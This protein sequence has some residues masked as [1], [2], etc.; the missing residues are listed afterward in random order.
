MRH[1]VPSVGLLVVVAMT[2]SSCASSSGSAG[3]AATVTPAVVVSSPAAAA[4]ASAIELSSPA[5]GCPAQAAW[6]SASRSPVPDGQLFVA[7]SPTLATWCHYVLFTADGSSLPP[8]VVA[9]ISGHTL[10]DLVASLN[11]LVPTRDEPP[12]P[13]PSQADVLTFGGGGAPS[14]MV[15][16]ERDGGCDFVWSDTGVHAYATSTLNQQLA[17][18]TASA[19]GLASSA[20]SMAAPPTSPSAVVTAIGDATAIAH[21]Q[22]A[23]KTREAALLAAGNTDAPLSVAAGFNTTEGDAHRYADSIGRHPGDPSPRPADS[24]SSYTNTTPVVVCILD[25]DI[26]APNLPGNPP[27][28]REFALISTDGTLVQLVAGHTDSIALVNPSSATP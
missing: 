21:C 10:T 28:S 19:T 8:P 11:A 17:A 13:G 27:Y 14:S 24:S 9:Q 1:V 7:G 6:P 26:G 25:G 23:E 12:C 5:A 16:I 2:V 15:H 3:V 22:A 20:A 18:I 4:S